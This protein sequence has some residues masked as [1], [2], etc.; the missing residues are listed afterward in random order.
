MSSGNRCLRLITQ[1]FAT[2]NSQGERQ[3]RPRR[4]RGNTMSMISVTLPDGSVNEY[5]SGITAGEIVIDIEGRKHDCVAAMVDGEQKDFSAILDS[6]CSVEGISAYS[7]EGIYIL[8]HSAAHLLAQAIT[9]IYPNAK[10][11]IGPPIDRGFYYDFADLEDFGESELKVVQK[12]MHELARRNLTVERVVCTDSELNELFSSNPYK[13]E[14]INDKI[15]EGSGST[16]Y[17]QGDWYDLCLGPH[18]HSTAKLMHVRLTT[19]SSAFWRGDQ[20]REQLTRIYGIVEP[21][22]DALKA[23]MSAIEEAKKRDHRKLGKDL[24]LFHVDED[25][26]QGL[27]LWTPRGAIIRSCLQEFI[28]EHLTRQGYHQ[29]F[30][31]HIGKLDLYRTS[32]HFPY[33]QD[34]QY[35]PLVEKDMMARLA[36]D[37]CSCGELSNMMA[38]GDI[39]GYMLKPMNCPHHIKIYSSQ[40]RSYRDLPLRL[41]EFGTVY[42]WEQ[43][44]EISGL[45]RVRGFT[46][47]DA[48]LFVT[49]DQ[50][51]HEVLGCIEL[52]QVIFGALGMHDYRV[53][54]GLR[55]PDSSKYVGDSEKWD[56][57]E[58]ACRAA[59]SSLGVNWSEEPGEAAFYG[60]KIDFVVKDVIGREW[61]LGTVQVDYNLPERFDLQYKGSDGEM[62]RPVMIHRAPFGSMERFCGV[63]IEHFAGRFPTWLAPTQIHVLTISEKQVEYGQEITTKLK[64]AGIR[65]ELDDGDDTI[66]KKIRMHRKFQPAYMLI[67]GDDEATNNTVSIRARNG[68]QRA[69][70]A[71]DTFVDEL[72]EEINSKRATPALVPPKE[73]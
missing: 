49:E 7:H 58:E 72:L 70:V 51:A 47:D 35:P 53:R 71:F 64:A 8:R 9:M 54:V 44:G 33:Y 68:D 73:E 5:A 69:G 41:A 56:L 2:D 21:T 55:D 20:S 28:S 65:A 57:A 24:Q 59:A 39:E 13:I 30:T 16:I 32:G 22:K 12:K 46:Q 62:H 4:G 26:G 1:F 63:L 25:V 18:V 14:I 52:V 42:R 67:L 50:I 43:S 29:V 3:K 23:T 36:N 66:G 10:P 15:E 27:I 34:S 45:T 40:A 60:P 11:T 6:D 17:R 19:V 38:A 61:Q 31:P 48:H 37:G